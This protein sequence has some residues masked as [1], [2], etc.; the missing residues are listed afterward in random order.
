MALD[1]IRQKL[2]WDSVERYKSLEDLVRDVR[3][4]FRNAYNYNTVSRECS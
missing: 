4:M 1:I 3:L 2:K